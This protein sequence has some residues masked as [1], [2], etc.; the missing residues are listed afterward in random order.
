MKKS[1][2]MRPGPR[3]RFNRDIPFTALAISTSDS[4][5]SPTPEEIIL[6]IA[7]LFPMPCSAPS[8]A[9]ALPLTSALMINLNSLGPLG[10][11][12]G[13]GSSSTSVFLRSRSSF[14][15]ALIAS[16]SPKEA[17]IS[18]CRIRLARAFLTSDSLPS[19]TSSPA[20]GNVF[21]PHTVTAIPGCATLTE[22]PAESVISLTLAK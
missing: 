11:K 18:A 12:V 14:R 6:V 10:S 22:F 8:T 19:R 5:T 7:S 9:S 2:G 4:I 15:T 21:Q 16:T 20:L 1:L 3:T 17:E 13:L